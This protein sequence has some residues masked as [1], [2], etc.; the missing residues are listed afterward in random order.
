M[1]SDAALSDLRAALEK[2]RSSLAAR[3]EEM[4]L[5]EGELSYDQNFAD[6][7]QVTAERGEVE[8]LANSLRESLG[9]VEAA[10]AKLDSG[11]YGT[12]ESCG[13]AIDPDRLEAKPAARLCM[14]CASRR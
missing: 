14:E 6:S 12:C 3:L 10:L 4:G 9:D 7:S 5:G 13:R 1:L 11:G 2:E 8:A